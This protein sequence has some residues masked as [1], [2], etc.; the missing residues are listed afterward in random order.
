MAKDS[1]AHCNVEERKQLMTPVHMRQIAKRVMFSE[2]SS[3]LS[4][5][6]RPG[7][8]V[9]KKQ[10]KTMKIRLRPSTLLIDLGPLRLILH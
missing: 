8:S 10:Q 5:L 1:A 9:A 3:E 7:V 4:L 6:L 2:R